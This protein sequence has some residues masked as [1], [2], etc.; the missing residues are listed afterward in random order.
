MTY[1]S[2][3]EELNKKGVRLVAVSKTKPVDMI[4]DLYN[5]GQRI[6]GENRAQEL[7]EKYDQLPRD[8]QWHMIG[9]LQKNKVKYIAPFVSMIESCDSLRLMGT[10]NKEAAKHDRV[11]PILLQ[12][13]I[14]TEETKYGLSLNDVRDILNSDQYL[15]YDHIRV[16]GLMGMATFTDNMD[17][18]R[19][20]FRT[21]KQAFEII[22]EEYFHDDPAFTEISM[23][24]SGDYS[25]AIE[26]G[27][28]MV[29]IGS[30]LFGAR[31]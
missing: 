15:S 30:L 7:A 23:G 26:E 16:A 13:R 14:A 9:H 2:L 10:I 27:S 28:T 12:M 31:G 24:M 21:L 6:F 4:L 11:I 22:K 25:T 8:I 5:Q 18:V 3:I 17:Q 19:R 1:Q 20:E 29:R